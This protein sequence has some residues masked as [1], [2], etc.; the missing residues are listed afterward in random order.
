MYCKVT[1]PE[2]GKGCEG[3]IEAKRNDVRVCHK[4]RKGQEQRDSNK[5]ITS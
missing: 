1:Q 4:V 3:V 2:S 5:N